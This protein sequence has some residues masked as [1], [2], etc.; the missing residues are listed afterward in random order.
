M[1]FVREQQILPIRS[2]VLVAIVLLD[3]LFPDHTLPRDS[4]DNLGHYIPRQ[5]LKFAMYYTNAL[6]LFFL[7]LLLVPVAVDF[8]AIDRIVVIFGVVLVANTAAAVVVVVA[9]AVDLAAIAGLD[10]VPVFV[11]IAVVVVVVVNLLD[12]VF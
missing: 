7:L 9:V 6:V 10:A 8:P 3:P 1:L 12:F 4:P 11:G 2:I 5:N